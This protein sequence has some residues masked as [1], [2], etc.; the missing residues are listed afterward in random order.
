MRRKEHVEERCSTRYQREGLV[1]ASSRGDGEFLLGHAAPDSV[2]LADGER[3]FPALL[4]N[5]A[6]SAHGLCFGDSAVSGSAAFAVRVEEDGGLEA[7]A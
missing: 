3:V 1:I 6:T 7:A 5:G 4:D 2:G